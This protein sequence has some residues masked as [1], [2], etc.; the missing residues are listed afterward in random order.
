M[1]SLNHFAVQSAMLHFAVVCDK[2]KLELRDVTL[3]LQIAIQ[4][5]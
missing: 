3:P 5:T 1:I 4:D 2:I